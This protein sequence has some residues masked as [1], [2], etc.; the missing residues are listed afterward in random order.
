MV[1]VAG[2][3]LVHIDGLVQ[4]LEMLYN[5]RYPENQITFINKGVGGDTS[6]GLLSRFDWDVLNDPITGNP[7][8][9]IIASMGYNESFWVYVGG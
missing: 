3:S 5:T 2:D 9:V 1:V 6:D 8:V 4:N 7:D